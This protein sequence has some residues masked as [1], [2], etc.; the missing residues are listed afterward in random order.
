MQ[1]LVVCACGCQTEFERLDNRGRERKYVHGHAG[2]IKRVIVE[3]AC[4]CDGTFLAKPTESKRYL[5]THQNKIVGFRAGYTPHNKGQHYTPKNIDVLIEGGRKTRFDSSVKGDRH[6]RYI[7]GRTTTNQLKR[8]QFRQQVKDEVLDRDDYTC[9]LCGQR[10][11]DLHIDHIKDWSNYPS[12]RFDA[13]NCR[14]LCVDCH[15]KVTFGREKPSD[16]RWG[17]H[18]KGG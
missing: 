2:R 4:G 15:Y 6:P 18:R 8:Q 17:E 7:D 13:S 3:C 10:G 5:R 9:V 11:G 14:T 1:T 12:L 16:S